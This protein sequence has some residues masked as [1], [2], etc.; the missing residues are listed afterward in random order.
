MDDQF[1]MQNK[2][3]S[4]YALKKIK[5]GK[6]YKF[7]PQILQSKKNWD[8]DKLEEFIEENKLIILTLQDSI[9]KNEKQT[10]DTFINVLD[11]ALKRQEFAIIASKYYPIMNFIVNASITQDANEFSKAISLMKEMHQTCMEFDSKGSRKLAK[12]IGKRIKVAEKEY[13]AMLD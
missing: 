6:E 9:R 8:A 10:R 1:K 5:F 4:K 12:M 2:I 7:Y 11:D 13:N 3:K